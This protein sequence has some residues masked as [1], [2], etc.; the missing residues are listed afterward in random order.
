MKNLLQKLGIGIIDIMDNEII[1]A[2][3]NIQTGN[4]MLQYTVYNFDKN[5]SMDVTFKSNNKEDIDYTI[6]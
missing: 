1:G 4:V 2:A 6:N 3:K 5:G